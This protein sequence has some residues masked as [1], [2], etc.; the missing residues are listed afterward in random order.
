MSLTI[1]TPASPAWPAWVLSPDLPA[2]DRI[3]LFDPFHGH[4]RVSFDLHVMRA[5]LFYHLGS[6][7]KIIY[8]QVHIHVLA[9]TCHDVYTAWTPME[10]IW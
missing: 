10:L 2:W 1:V 4:P 3:S 9:Q 7:G 8:S 5:A 6:I